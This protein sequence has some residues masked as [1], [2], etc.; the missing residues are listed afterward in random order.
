MPD[1]GAARG[2]RRRPRTADV[3][4]A[5]PLHRRRQ[6]DADARKREP[7]AHD[8]GA[9][10][11]RRR[12]DAGGVKMTTTKSPASIDAITRV[13]TA[14]YE[15]PTEKPESD[16]TLTWDHTTVVVVHVDAAGSRGL[17]FTYGPAAC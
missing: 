8:H 16:G 2:R 10:G 13:E 3:R 11:P 14:V 7:R 5:E 6:R 17:G 12:P 1:G 9:G 15:I 4:S